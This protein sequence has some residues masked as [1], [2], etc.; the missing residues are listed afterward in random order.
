MTS[1]EKVLDLRQRCDRFCEEMELLSKV[2]FDGK[3]AFTV[4]VVF[5]EREG[6]TSTEWVGNTSTNMSIDM[7]QAFTEKFKINAHHIRRQFRA[8]E[9]PN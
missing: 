7:L 9:K 4:A 2:A 1:D 3:L 6:E 5:P 8:G